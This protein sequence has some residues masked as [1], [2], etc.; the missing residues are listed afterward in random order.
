[1]GEWISV[2]D[3]LS[4]ED[5]RVLIYDDVCREIVISYLYDGVWHGESYQEEHD[6]SHWME[7]P[8]PPSV[9]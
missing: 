6:V 4:E 2:N 8:V 9:S 5:K 7:L 1:M 3:R